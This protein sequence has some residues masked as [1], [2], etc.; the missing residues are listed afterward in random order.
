MKK[1]LVAAIFPT[2]FSVAYVQAQEVKPEMKPDNEVSFN[3]ALTSDYRYRGISQTRL[4]AAL[5][6][7]ADYVHN[8][9]GLY[10]GAWFS[11]IKWTKDAGG[12]GNLEADLYA[13]RRGEINKDISY[14]IGVLTYVY[15]SNGL[16]TDANTTEIYGQLTY[17]PAYV[18]Y[19][20]AV[21]NLFGIADSKN[22]GYLDLGAN[23]DV[24]TGLTLNIHAGRQQVKNNSASS[25][26][27][28]KIGIT[29]DFGVLTGAVAV[30]GTN[31]SETSYA[32]P[33][34][35][36]FLGKTAL[37]VSISKTF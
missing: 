5:Q 32:S 25:Y 1:I 24:A 3:T 26:T 12:G 23:I 19:S 35:G 33:A 28:W 22:S 34:N 18:K 36:K 17:G 8:S 2:L 21:T 30:V 10:A 11:S 14:D 16:A 15:P 13:G 31:A 37:V 9:S 20:H 6:G 4:Q 27:D 29:K 7:G